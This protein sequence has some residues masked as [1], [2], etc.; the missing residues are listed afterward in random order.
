M[1]AFDSVMRAFGSGQSAFGS[2]MRAF[3]F[4]VIRALGSVKTSIKISV[5]SVAPVFVWYGFEK[6]VR[7]VDLVNFDPDLNH[8]SG[9]RKTLIWPTFGIELKNIFHRDG[10]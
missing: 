7:V 8:G 3:F 6:V 2:F 4:S 1:R 10:S 5:P 9:F